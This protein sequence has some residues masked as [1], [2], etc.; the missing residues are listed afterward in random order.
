MLGWVSVAHSCGQ[1]PALLSPVP[2]GPQWIHLFG[3]KEKKQQ[4]VAVL[5]M[6]ETLSPR[7]SAQLGPDSAAGPAFG[8]VHML[9]VKYSTFHKG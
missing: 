7:A 3:G 5:S 4:S 8:M 6:Q 1:S 2:L 9:P